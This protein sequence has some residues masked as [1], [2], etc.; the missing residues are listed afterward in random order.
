MIIAKLS[1][2]GLC[3]CV[4]LNYII[5]RFQAFTPTRIIKEIDIFLTF[6]Q[7]FNSN[8]SSKANVC[9]QSFIDTHTKFIFIFIFLHNFNIERNCI[10]HKIIVCVCSHCQ[11]VVFEL[12]PT[13]LY[14]L[15]G[16]RIIVLRNWRMRDKQLT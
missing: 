9:A 7:T 16:I 2:F 11:N 3:V 8:Y 13:I 12:F 5:W 15:N 10:W 1:L 6:T 4:C 14:N